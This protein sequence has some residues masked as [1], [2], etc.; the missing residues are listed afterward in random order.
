ML[1]TPLMPFEVLWDCG[2]H[3]PCMSAAETEAEDCG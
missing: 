3:E 1:L 2:C